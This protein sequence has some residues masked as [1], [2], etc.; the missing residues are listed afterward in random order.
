MPSHEGPDNVCIA[1]HVIPLEC[2]VCCAWYFLLPPD[3]TTDDTDTLN[4]LLRRACDHN[5]DCA[6]LTDILCRWHWDGE[7]GRL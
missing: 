6:S 3:G 2:A 4:K 5:T 1:R 7:C